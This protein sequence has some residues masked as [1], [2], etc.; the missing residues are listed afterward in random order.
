LVD[1]CCCDTDDLM[2]LHLFRES[3]PWGKV[4]IFIS[5]RQMKMLN[6][7]QPNNLQWML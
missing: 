4:D 6:S 2:I 3:G 1:L 5:R 7:C